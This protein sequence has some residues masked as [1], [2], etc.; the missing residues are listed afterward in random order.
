MKSKKINSDLTRRRNL[1]QLRIIQKFGSV[2]AFVLHSENKLPVWTVIRTLNGTK[3]KSVEQIL[4]KIELTVD[5]IK[6]DERKITNEHRLKIKKVI[7]SKIGSAAEFNRRF[8]EFSKSYISKIVNKK[9]LFFDEKARGFYELICKLDA[10]KSK[11][12]EKELKK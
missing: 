11:T 12:N 2:N 7:Y 3:K 4:N 9:K 8:P 5:K 6:F 10:T 1:L